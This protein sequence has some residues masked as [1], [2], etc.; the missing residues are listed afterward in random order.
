M[1]SRTIRFTPET[2]KRIEQVATDLGGISFQ[3]AVSVVLAR[4][5]A[6]IEESHAPAPNMPTGSRYAR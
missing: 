6:A 1:K 2:E 4:G 5:L 3:A